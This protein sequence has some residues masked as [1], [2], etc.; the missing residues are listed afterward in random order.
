MS[1]PM[2][3]HEAARTASTASDGWLKR[4]SWY[5]DWNSGADGGAAAGE[6]D[7]VRGRSGRRR[8]A[9]FIWPLLRFRLRSLSPLALGGADTADRAGLVAAADADA[10]ADALLLR[11]S[12][13]PIR[14]SDSC[15]RDVVFLISLPPPLIPIWFETDPVVGGRCWA[16]LL[17]VLPPSPFFVDPCAVVL[18]SAV[19]GR[20]F[21]ADAFEAFADRSVVPTFQLAAKSCGPRAFCWAAAWHGCWLRHDGG[22]GAAGGGAA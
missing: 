11:E 4:R 5:C 10:D 1:N 9:A 13:S 21:T 17:L 7:V 8:P 16:V 14:S 12:P 18:V 15:S 20:T 22:V 19:L 2:T 6:G 3:S